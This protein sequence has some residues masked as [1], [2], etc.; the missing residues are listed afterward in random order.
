MKTINKVLLVLFL[1]CIVILLYYDRNQSPN[2]KDWF[3]FILL[4]I[5]LQF[6]YD[7]NKQL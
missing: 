1:I 3:L 6:I 7:K 4:E 2:V 5:I